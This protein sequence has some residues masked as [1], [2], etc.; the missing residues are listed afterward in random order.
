MTSVMPTSSPMIST[1]IGGN[2]IV[3]EIS[4]DKNELSLFLVALP[5]QEII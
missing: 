1:V 2:V 5:P 4:F 3:S